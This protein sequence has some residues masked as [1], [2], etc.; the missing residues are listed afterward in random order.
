VSATKHKED[1]QFEFPL[2]QQRGTAN[3]QSRSMAVPARCALRCSS[4]A[5][6]RAEPAFPHAPATPAIVVDSTGAE[7]G[8]LIN[9]GG[10]DSALVKAGGND[11]ALQVNSKGFAATGVTFSY[12]TD[13]CTGTP[14]VLTPASNALYISY[15][16]SVNSTTDV[17]GNYNG[18]SGRNDSVLRET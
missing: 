7:V 11:F 10:A 1:R 17:Q 12:P 18:G 6:P 8:P 15:P 2:L 4:F 14:Y 9:T 13:A 3:R 5:H 16:A